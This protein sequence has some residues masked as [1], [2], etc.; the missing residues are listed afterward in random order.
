MNSKITT[1]NSDIT[2]INSEI[3]NLKKLVAEK[4]TASEVEAKLTEALTV[5]ALNI[6]G[7]RITALRIDSGLICQGGEE[8]ATQAWVESLIESKLSDYARKSHVHS[9]ND[10][11]GK[12][13]RFAPTSHMHSFSGSTN[14]IIGH[15]H[16][17]SAVKSNTGGMSTNY[18][19]TISISGTTGSN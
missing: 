10:I 2:N 6:N 15:T 3:T 14:I 19:K 12:P 7:A 4:V 5:K 17:V 9:W 18:T 1:I 8:V 11:S 16:Y 13:V